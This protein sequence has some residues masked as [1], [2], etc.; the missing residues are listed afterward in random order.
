MSKGF[1]LA[2]ATVFLFISV[3]AC[4]KKSKAQELVV[5]IPPGVNGNF[6]LEMGVRDARPLSLNGDGYLL[7]LPHDGKLQTSTLLENPHVTFRNSSNG[8]IWGYS[9]KIFST[10]DGISTGGKI[11][12][13]IGTQKEFEAEQNKKNKSGGFFT[14]EWNAVGA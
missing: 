7:A 4:T 12:F 1:L 9:Q 13:F 5:E 8:Q 10:G 6:V 2:F 3:I 11:E 14:N